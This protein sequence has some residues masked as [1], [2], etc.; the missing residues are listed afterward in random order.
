MAITILLIGQLLFIITVN[1]YTVSTQLD[2]MLLL[3]SKRQV[4]LLVYT[5]ILYLSSM[6]VEGIVMCFSLEAKSCASIVSFRELWEEE[7]RHHSH[8]VLP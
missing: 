7:V 8:D 6:I 2:Q 4:R 5:R 3:V 1:A